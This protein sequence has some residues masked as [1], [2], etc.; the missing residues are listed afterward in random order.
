MTGSGAGGSAGAAA[1]SNGRDT[2]RTTPPPSAPSAAAL[3]IS[4]IPSFES[5]SLSLPLRSS[6]VCAVSVA[7]SRPAWVAMSRATPMALP[8][9]VIRRMSLDSGMTSSRPAGTP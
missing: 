2:A 4:E 9:P 6:A 3:S 1:P 8:W 7:P 5:T